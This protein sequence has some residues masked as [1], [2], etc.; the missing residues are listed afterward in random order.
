M[1]PLYMDED[2]MDDALVHGL[3]SRGVDVMTAHEAGMIG[4]VDADHLEFASRV[5]RVLCTHNIGDF[6][7]L[8]TQYLEQGRNHTGIIL[9]PQQRY[10]T[11]ELLRRLLRLTASVS[12]AAMVGSAEFVS[13]WP[14]ENGGD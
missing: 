14:P 9:M 6:W 11:G 4:R 1:L 5:R 12:P 10:A 3:R 8:H 13:A 2:S 7:A